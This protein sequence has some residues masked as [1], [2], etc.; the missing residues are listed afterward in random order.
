[1]FQGEALQRVRMC[2][3]CRVIDLMEGQ[4]EGE[5]FTPGMRS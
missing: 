3:D 4:G 5:I 2:E 1:M